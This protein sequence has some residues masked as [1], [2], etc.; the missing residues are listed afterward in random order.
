M[1]RKFAFAGAFLTA[2]MISSAAFAA[3]HQISIRGMKFSEKMLQVSVGDTVT[4]TNRDGAPHTATANDGSFDTGRLS[5]G[6][7]ATIK[8]SKAGEFAYFCEVH[9]GMKAKVVAN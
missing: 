9:P 7:S 3:D 5:R 4:F 6:E 1:F 2:A 8:I